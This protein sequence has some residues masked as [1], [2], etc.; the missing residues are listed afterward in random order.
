MVFS[1]IKSFLQ[2]EWKSLKLL[3]TGSQEEKIAE[4]KLSKYLIKEVLAHN[5]SILLILAT[6]I[7]TFG[8]ISNSTA[9][10]IGAMIIAPL[11][12]PII[13]FAYALVILNVRLLSYSFARLVYGIILT[14]AIAFVT[15]AII[16]FRIPGSE[17]L[18]RTEPT[19][20][21]L[22][23]AVAAGIAGGFAKVRSS[24]SDAI[25]GV[26]I[27]VALVP[28]L[29]VVGIGLAVADVNLSTGAFILFL[30]N[31]VSIILTVAL[32]FILESYGSWKKAIWGLL[33]L[34]ASLFL[35][36]LPL[37]F[38]FREMIAKNHIRHALSL[39]I[40][41]SDQHLLESIEVE[42]QGKELFVT[43]EVIAPTG[44]VD[45]IRARQNLK[46]AQ[47][48]LSKQ[49][50]KPVHLKVIIFPIE[51]EEYEVYAP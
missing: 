44:E 29:C 36:T 34:I 33:F 16:G 37:N 23:V 35:I 48:F 6:A 31:L 9:T 13:S 14:I 5:F 49:V 1:K 19:L 17:I 22:G 38:N 27:A 26:A 51:I 12:C 11:M 15:T 30:T 20:L 7:A 32:V 45:R 28:P 3:R 10:I 4:S 24:V 39:Y 43:V 47:A 42:L 50:G 2:Q 18:G 40:H 25:P 41:E 46:K 21:D 8:L